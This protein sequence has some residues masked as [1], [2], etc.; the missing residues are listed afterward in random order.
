MTPGKCSKSL[1]R[2]ATLATVLAISAFTAVSCVRAVPRLVTENSPTVDIAQLWQEPLDLASRDLFHGP[3]GKAL[4]P[5]A[6]TPFTFVSED[7][8]GYSPGYDVRDPDGR[9]WSVKLGP[10]A[11]TEVVVSRVLWAIGYHQPPIY[12]LANWTLVG[13]QSAP[14][15]GGRF[16]PDLPDRQPVGTWSWYENEF[17]STQPFKGLI[18]ANVLLNN[19]DWKTSNNRVYQVEEPGGARRRVHVVRDLGASLGRTSLSPLLRPF[20]IEAFKQ[21]SRN[22]IDGFESQGFI[23]KV[24]GDRVRFHYHGIHGALLNTLSPR[25][26]VWACELMSRLSDGQW[27]DAFRA[28]GYSPEES[29]RYVM[30]IKRKIAEGLA[31]PRL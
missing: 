24:T 15:R 2:C 29:R 21:G 22:D 27:N 8:G 30:K 1:L 19:W 3:G 4:A 10:E 31:L 25:D 13:G 7:R 14:Q 11:Q 28:A 26:V 20:R 9:L 12:Y 5:D 23:E 16:R 17:V 6:A 18:V